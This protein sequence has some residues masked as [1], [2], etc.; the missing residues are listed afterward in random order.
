M[1]Y[2]WT[3]IMVKNMKESKEFYQ[4][5]VGLPLDH[6]INSGPEMEIVFLG[7]GETKVELIWDKGK[8]TVSFGQD[9]SIGFE[10]DSMEETIK[11]LESKGIGIHS[12][13]FQPNPFIRFFY[14]LDPNNLKVQFVEHVGR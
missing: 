11:L 13:P 3:T 6:A 12:G 10:V 7:D 14:V 5:I 2:C 1:N 9:I 8:D 4:E